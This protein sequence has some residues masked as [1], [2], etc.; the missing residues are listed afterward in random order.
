MARVPVVMSSCPCVTRQQDYWGWWYAS[1]V[2]TRR[3][4]IGGGA[5]VD[6]AHTVEV[7]L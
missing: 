2:A 5:G 6:A 4:C 7:H 3:D 1:D